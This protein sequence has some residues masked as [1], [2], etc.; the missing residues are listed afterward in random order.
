MNIC[1]C[2]SNQSEHRFCRCHMFCL[3]LPSVYSLSAFLSE[4]E[5]AAS[6]LVTKTSGSGKIRLDV[7]DL[8]LLPLSRFGVGGRAAPRTELLLICCVS[9]PKTKQ[10]ER[11][12]FS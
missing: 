1:H 8:P 10:N 11:L 5:L 2:V 3:F 9:P 6:D 4:I 12:A 7:V